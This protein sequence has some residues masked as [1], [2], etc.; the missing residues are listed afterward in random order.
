M[1]LLPIITLAGQHV[2][3]MSAKT[4]EEKLHDVIRDNLQGITLRTHEIDFDS[5]ENSTRWHEDL[6]M[7]S[8]DDVEM[9]MAIE[10][11]FGIEI[12]DDEAI[13]METIGDTIRIID[14]KLV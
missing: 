3:N 2:T 10:E 5:L 12:T 6:K 4:T 14:A 13:S 1:V 7:D 11:E 9:L 8:L